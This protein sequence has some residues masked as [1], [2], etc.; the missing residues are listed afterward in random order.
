MELSDGS[1]FDSRQPI[2]GDPGSETARRALAGSWLW[3]DAV[4]SLVLPILDYEGGDAFALVIGKKSTLD[5]KPDGSLRRSRLRGIL[6]GGVGSIAIARSSMT[7]PLPPE[8]EKVATIR[9][10][11]RHVMGSVGIQINRDD[12]CWWRLLDGY[13]YYLR[14][15]GEAID[16]TVVVNTETYSGVGEDI[17]PAF[18]EAVDD[19]WL[20][21]KR[22]VLVVPHTHRVQQVL[23]AWVKW[24]RDGRPELR[25]PE[26]D[27]FTPWNP[28]T[29]PDPHEYTQPIPV[30]A[31]FHVTGLIENETW[32]DASRLEAARRLLQAR[33]DL[34]L[35]IWDLVNN[36]ALRETLLEETHIP[37]PSPVKLSV[38]KVVMD[39]AK[40]AVDLRMAQRRL[41]A[42]ALEKVRAMVEPILDP[43]GW[44]LDWPGNYTRPLTRRY[45]R[46]GDRPLA[47]LSF[48]IG[49]RRTT[50]ALKIRDYG[51]LDLEKF[52]Q[53]YGG[54]FAYLDEPPP[55]AGFDRAVLWDVEGGW[56]DDV[57]WSARAAEVV[58][59]GK[60]V[61]RA[62]QERLVATCVE[63]NKK[64][65]AKYG[66]R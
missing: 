4:T 57:D 20:V 62:A 2:D 26:P 3:W 65:N 17:Y 13:A 49:R 38:P 28:E 51:D 9:N 11:S 63:T 5:F 59:R 14:W 64:R 16:P 36:D 19:S 40:E 52:F 34:K 60:A 23:D 35:G 56:A 50:L 22:V 32:Q 29:P 53:K 33:F 25:A 46:T 39:R 42:T 45:V 12:G 43:A 54:P 58:K 47:S 7:D 66:L 27:E 31:E 48:S 6:P 10:W 37:P 41:K 21:S 24:A 1:G 55:T 15:A 8:F 44:E 61:R 18:L 30:S